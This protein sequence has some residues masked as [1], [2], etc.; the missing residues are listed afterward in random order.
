MRYVALTLAQALSSG[1]PNL[2][3]ERLGWE[4]LPD[5][6]PLP[7]FVPLSG[8]G[9]YLS[10]LEDA[11][12][13]EPDA[14]FLLEYLEEKRF[15]GLN[16]P[17]DYLETQLNEGHC[18]VLLDGLDEVARFEDR[19]FISETVTLF[20]K[21]YEGS[22]VAVTC[23]PEGYQ[24]GA[25]L[26]GDFRRY[27][28]QPL[29]WPDD[30]IR[31]IATWNRGV[32]ESQEAAA[33]NAA[34]FLGRLEDTPQVRE[35]TNNPLLLTVMAIV[36]YNVGT[37]PERRADLYD[38]CTELLLGW[39]TRWGRVLAAP[40]R[41]LDERPAKERRLPLEKLAFAWQVENVLEARR[42]AVE[43]TLTSEFLTGR[44]EAHQ[45]EAMRRANQYLDWVVQRSYL[46]RELG[47]TLSFYRRAFQEYLAARRLTR[48][49]K[50]F[51]ERLGEVLP[52]DWWE[53]TVLLAVGH[54]SN[55]D[56]ERGR[57][58]LSAILDTPDQSA[59]P[60][61]HAT[62]AARALL[63]AAPGFQS[64][65]WEVRAAIT[66]RLEAAL[67]AGGNTFTPSA[68]VAA[69]EAL[70]ALGDARDLGEMVRVPSGPFSMGSS[71][72][73]LAFWKDFIHHQ[74]YEE[75]AEGY[76][77]PEG[78]S[79]EWLYDVYCTWLDAE[80]GVHE[81]EIDE[82]WIRRYLITNAQYQEFMEAAG[83]DQPH[84]WT[85]AGW[86]WRQG[87][88]VREWQQTDRPDFWDD[89]RFN[90]P[91]RPVVGV[92][93]Y[94][95]SAY[96][97]WLTEVS[98]H[99]YRLP[100]EAEWEKAA[101]G[102]DRRQWPWGDGWDENKA[103]T[104]EGGLQSTNPVGIYPEGQSPFGALDMVGNVWEWCSTLWGETW[105][106]PDFGYPY[107]ADDGRE[108]LDAAGAR[109]LRGGSWFLNRSDARCAARNGDDPYL[110]SND[111]GFRLVSPVSPE[112]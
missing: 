107:R 17:P 61:R 75:E 34:D 73:E 23:R 3:L 84:Y 96:C 92:T 106:Q 20:S 21:R 32:L 70:G 10:G 65:S 110:S 49:P 47:N 55:A 91:N 87:E 4:S 82:F 16:L 25:Q 43:E 8:F 51:D 85:Q 66:E 57:A 67:H 28:V 93:W 56:P 59:A 53:E 86:T 39:D 33:D 63:E 5:P 19:S 13:P 36:H 45:Q 27:N 108:D 52:L 46:M 24:K 109:L 37:L 7:L 22:Y 26:G 97:R 89:P 14:R 38:H 2:V 72:E 50:L 6:L 30:V 94:E 62:L 64:E 18:L 90:G 88:P 101:R 95:A 41:W 98:D 111:V 40:P 99:A 12:K 71:A 11:D 44:D 83:Y 31:F 76:R 35:L 74:I 100:N 60:H 105:R 102:G 104:R 79:K 112:S 9:L 103:N 69:G 58:L 29:A 42:P 77:P 78:E 68:R 15:A 80:E 81:L 54:L 48:D 1:R